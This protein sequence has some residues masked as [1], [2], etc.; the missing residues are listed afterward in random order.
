MLG[1]ALRHFPRKMWL[2]KESPDQQCIHDTVLYL[3]DSEVIEYVSCRRLIAEPGS[4]TPGIDLELWCRG[5]GYFYQ[6][7][8]EAMDVIRILRRVT[9]RLLKVL[10]EIAWTYTAD[11]PIHGRLS[12]GEWLEIRENHY[13]EHIQRMER[14]YSGWI[15]SAARAIPPYRGTR[16][17]R[18]S[19]LHHEMVA[20]RKDD[21]LR[22]AENLGSNR[23]AGKKTS[24]EVSTQLT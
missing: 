15:E 2:Y 24:N 17:H 4:S 23:G 5:L 6:D 9:Y 7:I 1:A 11:L 14:I 18:L 19:H 8:R 16:R 10:P 20:S 21:V 3:A 12:L 22:S 13:P